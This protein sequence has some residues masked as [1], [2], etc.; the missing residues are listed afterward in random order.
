MKMVGEMGGTMK[1]YG[2]K[3]ILFCVL[4]YTT[5]MEATKENT[6]SSLQGTAQKL[7]ED[8]L[9]SQQTKN[10]TNA[11]L[12]LVLALQKRELNW[13]AAK[14]I[15]SGFLPFLFGSPVLKNTAKQALSF[16]SR[17]AVGSSMEFMLGKVVSKETANQ[18]ATLTTGALIN[19]GEWAMDT[20]AP[21]I[22]NMF[23]GVAKMG[24]LTTYVNTPLLVEKVGKIVEN[25]GIQQAEES[26]GKKGDLFMNVG[27]KIRTIAGK[28]GLA[29]RINLATKNPSKAGMGVALLANIGPELKKLTSNKEEPTLKEIAHANIAIEQKILKPLEIPLEKI[30]TELLKREQEL[31]AIKKILGFF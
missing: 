4:A 22:S 14:N 5:S 28:I 31:F 13:E 24:G 27:E 12:E 30:K 18:W 2:V 6:P 29:Q 17:R 15:A 10:L 25:V 7:L 8:K 16:V 19:T 26:G 21:L 23:E 1:N 11:S 9:L 20:G 3:S